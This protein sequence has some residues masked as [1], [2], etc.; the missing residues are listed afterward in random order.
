MS[1]LI[2]A[3]PVLIF[4]PFISF[5]GRLTKGFQARPRRNSSVPTFVQKCLFHQVMPKSFAPSGEP[6]RD[7]PGVMLILTSEMDEAPRAFSVARP[8]ATD[9]T[10]GMR[11]HCWFRPPP[12]GRAEGGGR[13]MDQGMKATRGDAAALL[14]PAINNAVGMRRHCWFRPPP[15][16]RA[17]GGGR[18]AENGSKQGKPMRGDATAL[19]VPATNNS[20]GMRPD[21]WFRPPPPPAP[22]LQGGVE[23]V[24]AI[25]WRSGVGE[26]RRCWVRTLTPRGDATALLVPATTTRKDG[27][28]R[29]EGGEWIKPDEGDP[30]GCGGTG[31]SGHQLPPAPALQVR[32]AEVGPIVLG[33]G[34]V[35]GW[36]GP[37]ED[38]EACLCRYSIWRSELNSGRDSGLWAHVDFSAS[39]CVPEA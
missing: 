37:G 16:G 30:R 12:R 8:Q 4:R 22:P 14:V 34:G 5:R 36:L 32:V 31:G 20:V 1:A 17:E 24:V 25:G 13:R 7:R 11:R 38:R 27:G 3:I 39:P 23:E 10:V 6:P 18:R 9:N 29:A 33:G 21:C 15:R 26:R 35:D 28:R 19:L 2:A